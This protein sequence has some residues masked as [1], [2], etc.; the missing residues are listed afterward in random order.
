MTVMMTMPTM[1]NHPPPSMLPLEQWKTPPIEPQ[2]EERQC[3]KPEGKS[4]SPPTASKR[5]SI[6]ITAAPP[7]QS[8]ALSAVFKKKKTASSRMRRRGGVGRSRRSFCFIWMEADIEII[9]NSDKGRKDHFEAGGRGE[10]DD[11]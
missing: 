1:T 3:R 8:L 11:V 2:R 9:P 6:Q 4:E 10:L 7:I 5:R